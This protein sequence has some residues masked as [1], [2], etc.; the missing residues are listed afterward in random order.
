M[1][2]IQL[3]LAAL[4]LAS[5]AAPSRAAVVYEVYTS[6]SNFEA[7]LGGDVSVIDFDDIATPPAAPVAFDADRYEATT[8]ATIMG[9]TDE[10]QYVGRSFGFPADFPA[11][12]LPN[13]YAPGPVATVTGTNTTTLVTFTFGG[14][15]AQISGFGAVFIDADFPQL[16]PSSLAF[17]DEQQQLL[18]DSGAISGPNASQ[19]FRGVI[20]ADD[21]SGNPVT[22]IS[23]VRLIS[24]CEWPTVDV[25]EGVVLDDFVFS[26]VPEPS[27]VALA[28][29]ALAALTALRWR[30]E[31]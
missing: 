1:E 14:Q 17:F 6:R 25:C 22:A 28:C 10:G 15:A 5:T 31:P 11:S 27:A 16:G 21:S 23:R 2:R 20:A 18:F 26:T 3:C 24:G 13:V 8:G 7:R 19:V 12:S 9:A 29:A 4:L 30:R